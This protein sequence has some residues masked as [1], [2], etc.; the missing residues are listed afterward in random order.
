MVEDAIYADVVP[1]SQ[2]EGD[3]IVP[4]PPQKG[5]P[6]VTMRGRNSGTTAQDPIYEE[7]MFEAQEEEGY[8]K[9]K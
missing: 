6:G 3:Y 4:N 5:T 9:V 8:I 7:V 2:E 1:Q